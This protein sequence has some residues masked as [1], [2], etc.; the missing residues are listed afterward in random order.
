[1]IYHLTLSLRLYD[2]QQT[3]CMDRVMRKTNLF[4]SL[5]LFDILRRKLVLFIFESRVSRN[6]GSNCLL[7]IKSSFKREFMAVIC[8]LTSEMITISILV[9][10]HL[11]LFG[12]N[13]LLKFMEGSQ[14]KCVVLLFRRKASYY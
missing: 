10:L 1:M 14:L 8:V 7:K 6:T 12:N 2:R 13:V 5:S 3:K 9:L 4:E 11:L